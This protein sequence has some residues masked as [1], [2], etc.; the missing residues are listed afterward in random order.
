MLVGLADLLVDW[1]GWVGLDRMVCCA[2]QVRCTNKEQVG[3]G[4]A[5][6]MVA[7]LAV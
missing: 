3:S 1:L 4:N 2:V 6:V 7:G 5:G